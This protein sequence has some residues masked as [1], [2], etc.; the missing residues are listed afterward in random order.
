MSKFNKRRFIASL[1]I[2][3]GCMLHAAYA[4]NVISTNGALSVQ[5]IEEGATD[6]VTLAPPN[7]SGISINEFDTFEVETKSL[8]LV[9]VPTY[10]TVNDQDESVN[11]ASLIVIRANEITINNN[12]TLLGPAADIVFLT[13]TPTGSIECLN[14]SFNNFLR[15]GLLAA[16]GADLTPDSTA[17]GTLSTGLTSGAVIDGLFAPGVIGLDVLANGVALTGTIDTHTRAMTDT[18]GGYTNVAH[19][20]LRI[21]SALTSLMIGDLEWNYESH[22]IESVN[23]YSGDYILG[24]SILSTGVKVSVTGDI[25]VDT[26]IDTRT[27]LISSVSYKGGAHIPI[28]EVEVY[29]FVGGAVQV[30]QSVVSGGLVKLA[31]NSD[32]NLAST[33]YVEANKAELIAVES[34]ENLGEVNAN[35]IA[36]GGEFVANEGSLYADQLVE[37]WAQKDIMN[38]YGGHISADTIRLVSEESVVRNGSR[39]PYRSRDI[40]AKGVLGILTNSYIADLDVTKLGT[41]YS[42]NYNPADAT[43]VSMADS[44]TAH[45]NARRLEVRAVGFENINPYYQRVQEDESLIYLSRERLNQV[46]VSVEDY[47][48]IQASSYVLN[49]SA[50]LLQN[51]PAGTMGIHTAVFANERYRVE[52]ILDNYMITET[53]MGDNPWDDE[54]SSAITVNSEL[55][56]TKTVAYSP[57]GSIVAMG[58]FENISTQSFLNNT[59]YVEIFGSATVDTPY[60]KDYG[61][62]NQALLRSDVREIYFTDSYF[63]VIGTYSAST[64]AVDPNELDSLFYVHGNFIASADYLEHDANALFV[65]HSPLDYFI[66]QAIEN[67]VETYDQDPLYR[68]DE[69]TQEDI[70]VAML[71]DEIVVDW[72]RSEYIDWYEADAYIGSTTHVV[73]SGST[74]YSLFDTLKNLYTQI[75]DTLSEFYNEIIWW[76]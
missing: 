8:K 54:A 39:T 43:G 42:L 13:N 56:T 40:D 76:E 36:L 62:E 64:Q 69:V 41:Y 6:I 52:T 28:E 10:Q 23:G 51:G 19:G 9:N 37:A 58:D 3:W 57:P 75:T 46:R 22:T 60:I 45:I 34:I 72:D 26:D 14:C 67:L 21:G 44:N 48:A 15:L 68:A 74:S 17:L 35:R 73:E 66:N 7:A 70:E 11:A 53:T 24:G 29:S 27:D 61:I 49:S 2:L 50:Q 12:V 59:A 1:V 4:S 16:Y 65:N 71:S 5:E 31:A 25:E 63:G 30:N 55:L 47:L 20:N 18:R 32:L 38:R 33:S